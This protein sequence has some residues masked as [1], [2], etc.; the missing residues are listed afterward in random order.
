MLYWSIID[1]DIYIY[2]R[3]SQKRLTNEEH[4]NVPPKIMAIEFIY[5]ENRHSCKENEWIEC[6]C[7]SR[8]E[9]NTSVSLCKSH[10]NWISSPDQ[11]ISIFFEISRTARRNSRFSKYWMTSESDC[12][13]NLKWLQWACRLNH[14]LGN[15][16]EAFHPEDMVHYVKCPREAFNCSVITAESVA[17]S[18]MSSSSTRQRKG[19]PLTRQGSK[20]TQRLGKSELEPETRV[21]KVFEELILTGPSSDRE[22]L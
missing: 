4:H 16:G 13:L 2:R 10:N 1:I 6:C 19:T 17:R 18:G 7:S 22:P 21:G 14:M 11:N 9:M 8:C 15:T 5:K 3:F 12:K 20:P